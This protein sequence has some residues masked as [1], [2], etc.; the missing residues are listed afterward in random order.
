MTE[1]VLQAVP[2]VSEGRDAGVVEAIGAAYVDAGATLAAVHRDVDHHRAVHVLFGSPA[3]VVRALFAGIET[4][5]RSI[6]LSVQDG[7]HPRIGAAD[8]I[9]LIGFDREGVAAAGRGALELGERVGRELGLP[10]FLYGDVGKGRRPAFFRSG[11]PVRLQRRLDTGEVEPDFGPPRLHPRAGGVLVGARPPLIAFNIVLA[12]ADLETARAVAAAVRESGGG[13][14]GLQ[15]IGLELASTGEIQV[16][17]NVIDVEIAP[18]HE[19]VGRVEAEASTRGA[20]VA[21]GELVGLLPASV[22]L[23]AAA[24]SGVEHRRDHKGAPTAVSL[25]AAARSFR[26][27]EL[28]S[29]QVVEHYL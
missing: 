5:A 8:V 2:N 20:R 7:I 24:A 22:V 9:P 18:L 23:A 15:A 19:V 12:D 14:P 28:H 3:T 10:V 13:M 27:G 26:L 21:S 17:M 6:D 16:S 25:A 11:G 4:A 29:H 1:V